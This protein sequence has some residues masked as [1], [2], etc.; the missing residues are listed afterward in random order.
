MNNFNLNTLISQHDDITVFKFLL[1]VHE[2]IVYIQSKFEVFLC[3]DIE[4]FLY[5]DMIEDLKSTQLLRI[6]IF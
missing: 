6:V 5:R 1:D 2:F 4:K 3:C